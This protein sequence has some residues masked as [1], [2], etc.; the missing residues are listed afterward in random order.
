MV[1]VLLDVF[2]ARIGAGYDISCKFSTTLDRS[3]LGPLARKLEYKSLVGSFHRHEHNWLCQLSFLAKYVVGLGL[4]DLEG[5][6]RFFSKSNVL[7]SS[8][9]HASIFHRKQKIYEFLKKHM[10]KTDTYQSL[11][12]FIVNNYKQALELLCSQKA[13][14]KQMVDKDIAN[15]EVF[16]QWLKEEHEYLQ[17]LSWEPVQETLEIE[18]YQ[19]LVNLN[20]SKKKLDDT[21]ANWNVITPENHGARNYTASK[22]TERCHALEEFEKDLMVIHDLELRLGITERWIP[23]SNEWARA[24]EMASKRQYQR[25]L[26]K[27]EGLIVAQ[28]FELTKMNMYQTG[29]K[30]RKHIGNALKARSQAIHMALKQY[31]L[32]AAALCPPCPQLLWDIVVEYAFLADFDLLSDTHQDIRKRPWATPAARILMDEYFKIQRAHEEIK[33]LNIEIR[34][35]ITYMQ[36]EEAYLKNNE[37]ALIDVNTLLAHQ[38]TM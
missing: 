26:D 38:I 1:E 13:L 8:T 11:S 10:D 2:G 32:A 24:A 16:G 14:E 9:H 5:C 36:N 28:M 4:E 25:C 6:E 7:A 29:Y 19:K 22:E 34:R 23:T 20:A 12:N 31:N 30:L 15:Y 37:D 21:S 33:R 27:L 3:P 17:G 18:Y 35:I